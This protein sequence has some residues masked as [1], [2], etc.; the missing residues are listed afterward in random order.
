MITMTFAKPL[1][2]KWFVNSLDLTAKSTVVVLDDDKAI[3]HLWTKRLQSAGAIEQGIVIE[4]FTSSKLFAEHFRIPTQIST[5]QSS[6]SDL[7]S[8]DKST[9]DKLY[10]IDYEFLGQ[11]EN[12]LDVIEKLQIKEQSIL[13]TSR[14]EEKQV[15]ERCL[16]M[17]VRLIPKNMAALIPIAIA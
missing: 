5:S 1:P 15:L 14:Y 11:K 13:V 2:P 17:G 9:P 6:S 16:K 10:L 12:G 3:S 8:A 7:S 4:S